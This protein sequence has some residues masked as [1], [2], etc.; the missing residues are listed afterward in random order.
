VRRIFDALF[1]LDRPALADEGEAIGPLPPLGQ[2]LD[3]LAAVED[4]EGHLSYNRARH[5]DPTPGRWLSEDPC[6]RR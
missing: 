2:M 6:S 5:Y 1:M 4:A 3:Q